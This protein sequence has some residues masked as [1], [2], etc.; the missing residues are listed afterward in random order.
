MRE[1]VKEET[2][3]KRKGKYQEKTQGK[4]PDRTKEKKEVNNLYICA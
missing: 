1:N 2:K 4:I 3:R